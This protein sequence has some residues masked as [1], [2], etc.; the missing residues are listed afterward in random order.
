ML[1]KKFQVILSKIEDFTTVSGDVI[2]SASK[3]V[4]HCV[5]TLCERRRRRIVSWNVNHIRPPPLL[6][7]TTTTGD[8]ARTFHCGYVV[9]QRPLLQP[10]RE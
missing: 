9:Q 8:D 5:Y 2:K 1:H 3:L 10:R 6:Y 4:L 7:Y